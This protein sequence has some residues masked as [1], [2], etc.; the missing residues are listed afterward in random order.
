VF[1]DLPGLIFASHQAEALHDADA[2]LIVSEW[3]DLKSPDFEQIRVLLTQPLIFDGR[4]LFDPALVRALGL[5]YYVIGRGEA[6]RGV[7]LEG[8]RAAVGAEA[9][10]SEL[11]IEYAVTE[12]QGEKVQDATGLH[13]Q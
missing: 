3:R 10:P 12:F 2:L 9:D 4:N 6:P 1:G 11:A 7:G 8:W 5:E 13:V